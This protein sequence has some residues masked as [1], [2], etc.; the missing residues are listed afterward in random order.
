MLRLSGWRVI[1]VLVGLCVAFSAS[2]AM[3]D[4]TTGTQWDCSVD[5]GNFDFIAGGAV[6]NASLT[7][8]APIGGTHCPAPNIYESVVGCASVA[9][10]GDGNLLS[11]S[12]GLTPLPPRCPS[13]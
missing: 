12:V 1:G 13:P 6:D 8:W 10:Q 4:D 2:P 11:V 7:V 3:A 5:A 9:V